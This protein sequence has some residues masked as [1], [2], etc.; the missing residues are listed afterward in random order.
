[1]NKTGTALR[2]LAAILLFAL[3]LLFIYV[4]ASGSIPGDTPELPPEL[5]EPADSQVS[6]SELDILLRSIPT[7]VAGNTVTDTYDPEA[8]RLTLASL[9]GYRLNSTL[10]LSKKSVTEPV[11]IP[12]EIFG[13][14]TT[15]LQEMEVGRVQLELYDGKL[16]VDRASKLEL[17]GDDGTLISDNFTLAPAYLRDNEGNALYSGEDGYYIVR[18][19]TLVKSDFS[20]NLLERQTEYENT[21]DF[22]NDGEGRSFSIKETKDGV[23]VALCAANGDVLTGYDYLRIFNFSEGLAAAVLPDSSISFIDKDGK[24]VIEGVHTYRNT[25]DRHVDRMYVLPDTFGTESIGQ[26]YF[27][28]GI[29]VVREKTV[30]YVYKENTISDTSTVI[31]ANGEKLGI[32]RDY[33]VICASDGAVVV[34]RDGRYGVFTSEE[35]WA[36]QPVYEKIEP[37]YEGLAVVKQNGKYALYDRSGNIVLPALFDYISPVSMGKIVAYEENKGFMLFEKQI[38]EE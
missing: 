18:E 34:E 16:I 3:A 17:Y 21:P 28:H 37:Y 5:T 31:K 15:E 1:M 2:N 26:L 6:E 22:A 33:N 20:R 35:R 27:D 25:S 24:V 4:Y 8:L 10:S 7:S 11:R 19:N 14:Y 30:D 13:T 29:A 32:L 9:D 12:D 38:I 23:R 36:L